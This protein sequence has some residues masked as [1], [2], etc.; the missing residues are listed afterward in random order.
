MHRSSHLFLIKYR[1]HASIFVRTVTFSTRTTGILVSSTLAVVFI[2]T[3]V[4]VSGPLPFHL[5]KADASSTHDLLVSYAAKDTDA[6]GLPDWEEALYGTDPANPHSVSAAVTDG[7]AVSQGLVKPKFATATS[8][9]LNLNDIPGTLSGPTTVTDQFARTLFAQYLSKRGSTQPTNAEIQT[10]VM[11]GMTQLQA[12]RQVPS[13]F[14]IGQVRNAGRGEV[15]LRTYAS[16]A[17]NAFARHTLPDGNDVLTDLSAATMKDDSGAISRIHTSAKTYAA[18]AHDLMSLSVPQ[19]TAAPHLALA[20]SLM[21]LSSTLE[22]LASLRTDP[23][24]AMLGID[25]YPSDAEAFRQAFLTFARVYSAAGVS[26]P[27]GE[28]GSHFYA[29]LLAAQGTASPQ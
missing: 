11:E 2:G 9:A 16:D 4:A 12:T 10:F 14:N 28:P 24:R 22:D 6:D 18:I 27:A 17:E 20:N 15:A 1:V 3:A 5:N 26:I 21:R 29:T 13:A 25:Q 23:I 8:T 7:D 19:E